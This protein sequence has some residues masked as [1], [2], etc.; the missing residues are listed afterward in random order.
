[1]TEAKKTYSWGPFD[2]P[3]NILIIM[4]DQQ[5]TTQWFPDNWAKNN[6]TALQWLSD[7]GLSF[8]NNFSS[9]A[10]CG[11]SRG[12]I[13][14]GKYQ[15]GTGVW[16]NNGTLPPETSLAHMMDSLGYDVTYKGKWDLV[17]EFSEQAETRPNDAN[18][19]RSENKTMKNAYGFSGWTS[20]DMGDA[21]SFESLSIP[22]E[23]DDPTSILYTMGSSRI[24]DTPRLPNDSAIIKGPLENNQESAI[25][26]LKKRDKNDKPFFM[27]ASMVSPHD[28]F[29]YP[30][31]FEV[32]G[33]KE[34][35]WTGDNYKGF[36]TPPTFNENLNDKP[37]VQQDYLDGVK[38]LVDFPEP[39]KYL[40]FYA[41]L[42][43]LSDSLSQDLIDTL[44]ENHLLENTIIV[45][46]A[47][48][49]ELG[50]SH[51][52]MVQKTYNMYQETVNVPLIFSNPKLQRH[53]QRKEGTNNQ[54][55]FINDGAVTLADLAPT[56]ASI[57][58]ASDSE[59]TAAGYQGVDIS[60]T[61]ANP[62][63]PLA[64]KTILFTFW[65]GTHYPNT[66]VDGNELG[67]S[68]RESIGDGQGGSS[69][70]MGN[71]ELFES[72]N[73]GNN[74]CAVFDGTWKYGIYFTYDHHSGIT[75]PQY[76]MYN[77][78]KDPSERKNLLYNPS[79]PSLD[80][81]ELMFESLCQHLKA[82]QF[83]IKGWEDITS[84]AHWE[85]D[86]KKSEEKKH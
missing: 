34:A 57:G 40:Q 8:P 71:L 32:A 75:N 79:Q 76:E 47:D 30:N 53:Y 82:K 37:T 56:L 54:K 31:S 41:Y 78:A 63:I 84:Y 21:L 66:T 26:F 33:Y 49:G 18:K 67:E 58:G 11:P 4:T 10:P 74:I 64:Q 1:M 17:S 73:E 2:S 77:L 69:V 81:A 62:G 61:V 13:F 16:N 60:S 68:I 52:G 70:S 35:D 43:T 59:I 24:S 3:P 65:G 9:A 29:S 14:S 20:P 19:V 83:E 23:S 50:L 25:D 6:L 42:Q 12:V 39:E 5:R 72:I 55:P 51:G 22:S 38:Q 86:A 44:T 7:N 15:P 80:Q 45:R 46:I 85:S 27:V 36:E 28:V 48:H